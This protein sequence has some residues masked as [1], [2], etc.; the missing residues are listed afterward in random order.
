MAE[1]PTYGEG[2][3]RAIVHS[4]DHTQSDVCSLHV[5][6]LVAAAMKDLGESQLMKLC[7][8]EGYRCL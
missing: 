5:H 7:V 1:N 4:N 2:F 8:N 6:L 3:S